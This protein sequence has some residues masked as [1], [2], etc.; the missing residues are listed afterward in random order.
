MAKTILITA[1]ILVVGAVFAPAESLSDRSSD[2]AIAFPSED[3]EGVSYLGVDTRDIT[4][5]RLGP[6]HLKEETGVEITMV[7]QD[8]PAGKAGLKEQ[9]VILTLN[10]EKIASVEQLRRMIRETPS[11][12][13]ISLGISRNG[14]PMTLQVQLADRKNGLDPGANGKS[15]HVTLPAMPVMPEMPALPDLDL[16]VSIVVVHS[17]ARSGLMVENLTPQL[18]DYFGVKNGEGVLVRSVERGSRAEKAGFR[19]GDVITKVNGEPIRDSGDFTHA[20]RSRKD[21]TVS[22]GIVRDKKEQ[23]VTLSLPERKQSRDLEESRGQ[24]TSC[25]SE[26]QSEWAQLTFDSKQVTQQ[27]RRA[28]E[29][30]KRQMGVER[31]TNEM[32]RHSDERRLELERER[33]RALEELQERLREKDWE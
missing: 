28:V 5:D 33:D 14:Q 12:R 3:S 22:I 7:D 20:L 30:L 24:L 21:N 16:P 32:H 4:A 15:F 2:D 23:S 19:A 31:Q 10:G 1:V 6:L 26:L 18:G 13:V 29:D 25:L 11:G 9:D 27:S 17:S 8:A